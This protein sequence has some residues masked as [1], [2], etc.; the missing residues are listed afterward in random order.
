MDFEN[1]IEN[2]NSCLIDNWP[3]DYTS[4]EQ[5]VAE[6]ESERLEQSASQIEELVLG[7]AIEPCLDGGEDAQDV[8]PENEDI[9]VNETDD[10]LQNAENVGIVHEEVGGLFDSVKCCRKTGVYVKI[11]SDGFIT[12]VNSDIFIDNLEGWT[13]I[14]EGEGDKYDHAQ[15]QYFDSPLIDEFGNY[16][17]K[18]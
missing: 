7:G 15:S 11:N 2:A 12:D 6:E 8:F 13:K 14:D 18:M 9:V 17:H 5:V 3:V 10:E 16:T 1:E 4:G